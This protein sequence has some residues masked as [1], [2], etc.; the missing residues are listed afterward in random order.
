LQIK[1]NK[2]P[3]SVSVFSNKWKFAI[4]IFRF[5]QTDGSCYF[6]LVPFSICGFQKRGDGDIENE[7][8]ETWGHGDK[9]TWI[10]RD[11]ETWRHGDM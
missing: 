2:L 9:G 8:M 1:E 3:F 10:H 7:D 5:Q 11:K 4:I 6:P